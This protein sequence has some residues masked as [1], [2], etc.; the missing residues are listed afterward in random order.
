[1]NTPRH[2]SSAARIVACPATE[3]LLLFCD[4][5]WRNDGVTIA[6]ALL[7]TSVNPNLGSTYLQAVRKSL[8]KE[9]NRLGIAS[10]FK[11]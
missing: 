11:I 5:S 1:M 10:S 3:L 4:F 6:R 8:T 9:R 2:D 7:L